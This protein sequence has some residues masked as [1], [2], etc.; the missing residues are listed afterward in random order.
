LITLASA[1]SIAKAAFLGV[2]VP[3]ALGGVLD[4]RFLIKREFHFTNVGMRHNFSKPLSLKGFWA[5]ITIR[6]HYLLETLKEKTV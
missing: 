1:F 3:E 6:H 5:L 2:A 4:P